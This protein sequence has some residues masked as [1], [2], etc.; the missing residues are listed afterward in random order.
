MSQPEIRSLFPIFDEH[1]DWVYLDSAASAQKPRSV[2]DALANF[3][4]K[5]YA[6]VHRA[7]YQRS[8]AA[9]EKYEATRKTAARLLN[10]ALPEEIVF[11]RG[12]TDGI[13]LVAQSLG[14]SFKAG[15][16]IIVSEIEH[17]S[18]LVPWQMLAAKTGLMLR[19][20]PVLDD[21]S[22]DLEAFEKLLSEK[23]TLVCVTHMSN[24]T[25]SIFPIREIS[26]LC[27]KV[28]AKIL[29]DGA[30]AAAHLRVD[31]QDLDV[32]FYVFSGHKCYGPTGVGILYGKQKWL[33][34]MPPVQ[35]GGDMVDKVYFE[36]SSY[37]KAPLKFEAGTPLI[38][39]V[40]ALKPALDL[41]MDL[42]LESIASWER[43]L[44]LAAL[45]A[46]QKIPGIEIVGTSIDK[47]AILTFSI[48]GTHPLD[49]AF[50]LDLK[51]ISIRS[52]HLCAQTALKRFGLQCAARASF[53]IY[54][55]LEDVNLFASALS[56]V[57][58]SLRK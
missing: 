24:V 8:L 26:R 34:E 1:P 16:E 49:I 43:Q 11:T 35:G 25:G 33:E 13:N 45:E 39:S 6:T 10:A 57:A 41:L 51:N 36:K 40:I 2:I 27:R 32:D 48:D 14:S 37:Q 7:I 54:N 19:I 58:C 52:G 47:G 3:Y 21:G 44:Y 30:Q 17:H 23:T 38:A 12:A 55:T 9:T 46:V 22:F 15:D 5:E 28:G 4:S 56:D 20:A 29:V 53:G 18:N 31:V 50:F 42:G